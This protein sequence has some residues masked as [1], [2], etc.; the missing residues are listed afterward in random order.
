MPISGHILGKNS[1]QIRKSFRLFM[2]VMVPKP[3]F[4]HSIRSRGVTGHRSFA[5]I[6]IIQYGVKT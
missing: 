6:I 2:N 5:V 4:V 3:I 1:I